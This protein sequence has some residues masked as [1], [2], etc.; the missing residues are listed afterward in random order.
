MQA[1]LEELQVVRGE[2]DRAVEEGKSLKQATTALE[3]DKKVWEAILWNHC[4]TDLK[5]LLLSCT[6]LGR[7]AAVIGGGSCGTQ[8]VL[9]TAAA[10]LC[11]KRRGMQLQQ[12]DFNPPVCCVSSCDS[13]VYCV[14]S[15]DTI[16]TS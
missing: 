4:Q 13:T 7:K 6:A 1:L 5:A 11:L 15:Y 9:P 12:L 16:M 3:K 8:T 14:T 10:E 2:R